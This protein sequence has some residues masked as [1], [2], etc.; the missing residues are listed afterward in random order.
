METF[1]SGRETL[2]VAGKRFPDSSGRWPISEKR[3]I[4]GDANGYFPYFRKFKL[5]WD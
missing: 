4:I 1:P 3:D 5:L 2:R